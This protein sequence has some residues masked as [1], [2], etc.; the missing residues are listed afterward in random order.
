MKRTHSLLSSS[1]MLAAVALI[2]LAIALAG[3]LSV[4]NMTCAHAAT[5]DMIYGTVTTGLDLHADKSDDSEIVATIPQ[6]FTFQA[7]ETSDGWYAATYESTTVYFSDLSGV[8][9]YEPTSTQVQHGAVVGGNLTVYNAPSDQASVLSTI[10]WGATIQFASF[11]A[12]YY[13]ARLADGTL[14]YIPVSQV[15]LYSPTTS[16][17]LTLYAQVG[18]ANA[19]Q[20][21]DVSSPVCATFNAGAELHFVEFNSSWCMATYQ[22]RIVFVP[23]DQL[24]AEFTIN[25]ISAQ[26]IYTSYDISLTTLVQVEATSESGS[27]PWIIYANGSWVDATADNLRTYLNPSNFPLD[28]DGMYQFLLLDRVSGLSVSQLNS[29]LLGQGILEGQGQAFYD[30]CNKYSVNEVYLIA[31]AELETGHGTSTLANGVWYDPDSDQVVS[32]DP[33]ERPDEEK[34]PNA[35]LVYNMFGIGA[36]DSDPLNGGGRKAYEEG[37]TTPALAIEGGAEFISSTYLSAGST[38]LSGQNTLYKM[39]YHPEQAVI[40]ASSSGV[41][42]WHEYATDVAWAAKQASIM[43]R[44]YEGL[45]SYTLTFEV[46]TYAG[47]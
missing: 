42:P 22:G 44:I 39:L 11:N 27:S 6:G 37:W 10:E 38:T 8:A 40:N 4:A 29:I 7:I 36:Y 12:D 35:T 18:G 5:G 25:G 47:D 26:V 1:K 21:P 9:L 45:D 3:L 32:T 33:D 2:A 20:A 13:M 17:T 24:T 31:H 46:P 41:K 28:S 19:Y 23:R 14:C 34:Y 43:A 30:A 15:L 16:D